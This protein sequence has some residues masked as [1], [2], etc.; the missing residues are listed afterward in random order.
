[1]NGHCMRFNICKPLGLTNGYKTSQEPL[2]LEALGGQCFVAKRF[3]KPKPPNK[4]KAVVIFCNGPHVSPEIMI[5]SKQTQ[6]DEA[7]TVKTIY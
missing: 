7:D 5:N 3:L 6:W 4:Q 1:M 2:K